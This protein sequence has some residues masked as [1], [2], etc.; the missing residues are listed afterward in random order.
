M[1][2]PK[3]NT[4]MQGEAT[5]NLDIAAI[6]EQNQKLMEQNQALVAALVASRESGKNTSHG[7]D[8]EQVRIENLLGTILAF[9]VT[10]PRNGLVRNIT[11]D[12]RGAF[13]TVLKAQVEEIREK[14]PHFFRDGY[15]GC[16]MVPDSV[17]TIRDFH[18]FCDSLE[19]E[20]ITSRIGAITSTAVLY[21][22]F[23]FIE[24]QRFTHLDAAGKPLV[25]KDGEMAMLVMKEQPLPFKLA[26]IERAVQLRLAEITGVRI[27]LDI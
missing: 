19:Q 6:L 22:L 3:K 10:D 15:L 21:D 4:E 1:A 16:P 2:R 13:T 27:A 7:E 20:E 17:N 14:Y 25:E 24:N 12:Q 9:S 18:T 26:A 11:L 23:N 5:A 8:E